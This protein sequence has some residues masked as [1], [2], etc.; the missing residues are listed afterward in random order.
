LDFGCGTGTCSRFIAKELL[1]RNGKLTCFDISKSSIEAAKKRLE[2]YS[3]IDFLAG[4]LRKLNI[5]KQTFDVILAH[6]VIYHIEKNTRQDIV[7]ELSKLLK[8]DGIILVFHFLYGKKSENPDQHL[9]REGLVKIME[10]AGLAE[11][12]YT[13]ARS[14]LFIPTYIG[15][16]GKA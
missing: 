7:N 4:D 8:P 9:S 15:E 12:K 10:K 3:N 14:L 6:L 11:I 13:F 5:E 2:R 1:K 16:F